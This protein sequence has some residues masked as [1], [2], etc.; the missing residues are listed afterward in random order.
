MSEAVE[1]VREEEA[2]ESGGGKA[3][4][5]MTPSWPARYGYINE[6]G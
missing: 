2:D 1:T 3:G 4:E 6:I 5:W